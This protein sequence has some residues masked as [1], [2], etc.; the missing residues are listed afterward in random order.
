VVYTDGNCPQGAQEHA[1]RQG[2]VTVVPAQ[3]GAPQPQAP[4]EPGQVR[5]VNPIVGAHI[6]SGPSFRE[7][8]VER[9]TGQ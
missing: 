2:T 1:I 3:A 5:I 4:A 7:K 9:V 8:Q 6:D